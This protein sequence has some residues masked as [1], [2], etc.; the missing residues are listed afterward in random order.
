MLF[1][2]VCLFFSSS[3]PLLNLSCIFSILFPRFCIIFTIIIL[4]SFSGRLC[5][6]SS[7]VWSSAFFL[8]FFVCCIFLC[9]LVLLNLL[10][11]VSP[12]Y[13][14]QVHSSHCFLCLPPVGTV[15]SV[16][17]VGFLWMGLVPVLFCMGLVL[18]FLVAGLLLM[19]FFGWSVNLVWF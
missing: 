14:L 15:G 18:V 13:N 10:C 17:C 16:A 3:R 6:F 8:W 2:I 4:N 7:F 12:F 9:L 5:I 11:L 19:V 1:I